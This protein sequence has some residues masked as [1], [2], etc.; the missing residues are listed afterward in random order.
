MLNR[1]G[2]G[3]AIQMSYDSQ[4]LAIACELIN[5]GIWWHKSEELNDLFVSMVKCWLT[6]ESWEYLKFKPGVFL[7]NFCFIITDSLY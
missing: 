5:D 4:I 1:Y 6:N 3:F 2:C 7:T